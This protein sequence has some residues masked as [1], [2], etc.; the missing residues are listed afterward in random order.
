MYSKTLPSTSTRWAFLNSAK[1][2]TTMPAPNQFAWSFQY[3]LPMIVMSEG[4]RLG[5][6]GSDPPKSVF[7]EA[8][9]RKLFWSRT[10]PGESQ[11]A[12]AC[13]SEPYPGVVVWSWNS[14]K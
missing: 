7:S 4:T 1:F 6:E 10:G 11:D 2:F 12:I 3:Q 14:L 9:D 8:P 5:M 13:E